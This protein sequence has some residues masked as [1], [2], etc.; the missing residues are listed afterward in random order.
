MVAQERQ[1]AV[2]LKE[3]AKIREAEAAKKATNTQRL[4]I[5][6]SVVP[7]G[8]ADNSQKKT[9]NP[10]IGQSTT[11]QST[12]DITPKDLTGILPEDLEILPEAWDIK[13]KSNTPEGDVTE[14]SQD[15]TLSEEGEGDKQLRND[16]D[17]EDEI[18]SKRAKGP[19]QP[20]I[21]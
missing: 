3:H 16:G 21:A 12:G 17:N 10:A 19:L 15:Y 4:K 2:S 11:A 9:H 14:I 18:N 5:P 7:K 20:P 8:N 1:R 6:P 13:D